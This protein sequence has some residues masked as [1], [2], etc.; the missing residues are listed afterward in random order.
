V[1]GAPVQL[2]RMSY[3]DGTVSAVTND[4]TSYVGA[5]VAADGNTAVTSRSDRR[6][7]IFVSDALANRATEIVAP[8]LFSGTAPFWSV[9][10][11]GGRLFYDATAKGLSSIASIAIGGGEPIE[12]ISPALMPGATSD[13]T[14][15]VFAKPPPDS[16]VWK[17]DLTTGGRPVQVVS[18]GALTPIVTPDDRHVLFLSA[19]SGVQSPWFVPIEGG[20]PTE[21]I[22]AFAT[23]GTVD[24]SPD[25]RRLLFA[26]PD[27]QNRMK[28]VI[29]DLPAGANR[30]DL[31]PAANFSNQILRE[32]ATRFTPDGR[33]IAYTDTSQM[34][35]W[36]QPL[37]G[38]PS[39]QLTHFTDRAI[40]AFAWSRD[41]KRL[42]IA[43][44]TT[45]NDI[46]LFKGLRP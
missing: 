40:E 32:G 14:T 46:V 35:I 9:T 10:W 24:I 5:E 17:I 31:T 36:V 34:N 4:L 28:L 33:G 12:V 26:T 30:V 21:V 16:G 1:F 18:G 44:S 29:C 41:G 13:G 2:F 27:A 22:R 39:R 8:T 6:I 45:T 25:G 11:G 7:A 23:R 15:I 19:K 20:T 43:R 42:A 38:G 3:R 37:D